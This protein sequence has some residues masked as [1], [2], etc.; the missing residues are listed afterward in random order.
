MN[1]KNKYLKYKK[2]YLELKKIKIGGAKPEVKEAWELII[3][4]SFLQKK[5]YRARFDGLRY[6]TIIKT[7]LKE[8]DNRTNSNIEWNKNH[9]EVIKNFKEVINTIPEKDAEG[10]IIEKNHLPD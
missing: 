7:F 1:F 4:N 6:W 3:E 5:K 10:N 2:K 8:I 9:D